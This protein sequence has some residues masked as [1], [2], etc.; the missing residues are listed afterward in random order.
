MNRRRGF[1]PRSLE[2][3]EGRV[4]LSA[5]TNS[6]AV[7]A[8]GRATVAAFAS[9]VRDGLTPTLTVN[10]GSQTTPAPA[11]TINV[12]VV[13][14]SAGQG[15]GWQRASSWAVGPLSQLHATD[16]MITGKNSDFE[17]DLPKGTYDV[18]INLASQANPSSPL[19]Q[20]EAYSRGNQ[21][22]PDDYVH[23]TTPPTV[24]LRATMTRDAPNDGLQVGLTY[25]FAIRSIQITPDPQLAGSGPYSEVQAAPANSSSIQ[26]SPS[27]NQVAIAG[28][29][30]VGALDI[31]N[32]P[33]NWNL[34][35]PETQRD[36]YFR[37]L[38]S[39]KNAPDVEGA[40]ESVPAF[41]P[42]WGA[43]M[44]GSV[45]LNTPQ[46]QLRLSVQNPDHTGLDWSALETPTILSYTVQGGTGAYRKAT[47]SGTVTMTFTPTAES[48]EGIVNNGELEPTDVAGT[49][50]LN[51]Q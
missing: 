4:V 10:F 29:A 36:S 47:G 26:V 32:I 50:S 5:V 40:L 31:N 14:Y 41:I 15:Y 27:N 34:N 25:G 2:A 51:F 9:Q 38:S 30:Q 24:T 43:G 11:G 3:L 48:I 33:G 19:T 42:A 13:P 17:I 35:F 22:A 44:G 18:T 16:G 49:V 8:S 12:G 45:D 46:G 23:P 37:G 7:A 39:G 1:G 21:Q 20:L 28:T 6:A